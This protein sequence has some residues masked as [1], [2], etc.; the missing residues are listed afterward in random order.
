MLVFSPKLEIGDLQIL[1]E[2][3]PFSGSCLVV[4]GSGKT[5]FKKGSP[6]P[7]GHAS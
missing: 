2:N 7:R 6:Y 5:L 1:T 4:G 3:L